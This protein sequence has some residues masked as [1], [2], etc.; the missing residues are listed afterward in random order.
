LW[1]SHAWAG[2]FGPPVL[3]DG[4]YPPLRLYPEHVAAIRALDK[5]PQVSARAALMVDADSG[6]VLYSKSQQAPLPPAS[7]VKV[8]TALLALQNGGLQDRVTVSATAANTEG[9]R[10]GLAAGESL[11]VEELLYGLLLPSGNDAAVAL[12]E[13]VSGSEEAFVEQMNVR[14]E[15]LG[16]TQTHFTSAH[17]LDDP[18]QTISAADLITLTQA[19]LA[20]PE[21]AEIVAKASADVAGHA[22]TNTNE[23]LA[24]YPGADGIK[25]GTTDEAGECLAASVTRDGHR[26][27]LALLGS[28]DRYGD[29]RALLDYAAAGW[30]WR[31]L[32]LAGGALDWEIGPDDEPYRLRPLERR[33]VFLPA[34]Q[35]AVV[36]PETVLDPQVPLT[37]TVPAGAIRLRLGS[38][39]LAQAPVGVWLHP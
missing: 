10:M 29:A 11:S 18:A 23:L 1:P 39:T 14:A 20:Y 15:A 30:Q 34:W 24:S 16:L 33:E 7:T 12:A 38:E 2:D 25:T 37:A 31:P 36:S 19:A 32:T 26:V 9:S 35:W 8:M 6:E 27:L 22:L 13:H 3:T 28:T 21:F 17:G 4:G 5:P